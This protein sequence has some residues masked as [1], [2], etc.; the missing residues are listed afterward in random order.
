[1]GSISAAA[2]RLEQTVE[3]L[4]TLIRNRCVNTGHEESGEDV[5]NADTLRQFLGNA[6]DTQVYDAAEGRRSLVAKIH[7]SD[8]SAPSLAL[9]CHTDVVPAADQDWQHDPFGGD[10][11]DGVVWGRGAIDMLNMTA[12]MAAAL[13]HAGQCGHRPRGDISFIATAD[14]EAQATWGAKYLLEQ[15]L[16]DVTADYVIT[17]G[18][19]WPLTSGPH[20]KLSWATADKRTV[21]LR[22]PVGVSVMCVHACAVPPR[23]FDSESIGRAYN[24]S[25]SEIIGTADCSQIRCATAVYRMRRTLLV[26]N[27][28]VAT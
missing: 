18:G 10:L 14:E 26:T 23:G 11:I 9:L 16:R 22:A 8:P 2:P 7:G 17:E 3:L 25:A 5:R 4:Q 1:M 27:Q 21:W 6:V 19:G 15:H 12:T 20:P 24:T 13:R 28:P